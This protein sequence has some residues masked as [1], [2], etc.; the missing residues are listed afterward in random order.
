MR[1]CLLQEKVD[2]LQACKMD[3]NR[4]VAQIAAYALYLDGAHQGKGPTL[5][6]L[7]FWAADVIG[8]PS[9]FIDAT[10]DLVESS[11]RYDH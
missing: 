9:R 3:Q 11:N 1:R 7:A 4:A 6:E 10:S 2:L 5:F 8:T